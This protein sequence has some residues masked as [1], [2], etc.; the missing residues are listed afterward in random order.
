MVQE[1]RIQNKQA[2]HDKE[3]IIMDVKLRGFCSPNYTLETKKR[4]NRVGYTTN[5]RKRSKLKKQ[6]KK[7][8]RNKQ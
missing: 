7:R 2:R 6:M 8:N 5:K 1:A 3:I 4:N